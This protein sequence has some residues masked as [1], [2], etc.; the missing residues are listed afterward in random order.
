MWLSSI[1]RE[2]WKNFLI[3]NFHT[4]ADNDRHIICCTKLDIGHHQSPS[5]GWSERRDP[6]YFSDLFANHDMQI[7]DDIEQDSDTYYRRLEIANI[8]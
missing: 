5:T 7:T 8:A 4:L 6:F 3:K 2:L 1:S